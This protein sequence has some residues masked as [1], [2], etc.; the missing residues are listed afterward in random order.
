MPLGPARGVGNISSC[1]MPPEWGRKVSTMPQ[2]RNAR[3]EQVKFLLLLNHLPHVM[4]LGEGTTLW[5]CQGPMASRDWG[6]KWVQFRHVKYE[7]G[8]QVQTE[9]VHSSPLSEGTPDR[10]AHTTF[11][12][13]G[14]E[15]R[16]SLAPCFSIC[17]PALLIGAPGWP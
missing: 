4:N 2:K 17:P 3:E 5:A 11:S 9:K 12:R 16:V 13:T 10:L 8:P 1:S 15:G 7:Q 14:P 6:C